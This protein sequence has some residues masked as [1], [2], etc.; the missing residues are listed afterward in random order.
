L[1]CAR[2]A[3]GPAT[4]GSSSSVSSRRQDSLAAT[5]G[6]PQRH[7]HA[8]RSCLAE[9]ELPVH[10]RKAAMRPTSGL[11]GRGAVRQGEGLQAEGISLKG[12]AAQQ[13]YPSVTMSLPGVPPKWCAV[14]APRSCR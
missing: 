12:V 1:R 9:V 7:L 11:P 14:L 10:R 4:L 6:R 13:I 5:D 8:R 2:T 3:R